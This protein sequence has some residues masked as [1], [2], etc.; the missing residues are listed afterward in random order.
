LYELSAKDEESLD[1]YEGV[2]RDYVKKT[3]PVQLITAS[4]N[5]ET[6]TKSTVDALVYI[7]YVNTTRGNP[8]TEYIHRMNMA[9][10][11]A[12]QKDVPQ[13]FIDKYIRPSIPS[14]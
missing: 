3:I 12:I 14:E 10:A 2:P 8:K 7:D 5:S 4:G 9:V 1:R 6:A 13:S 11:D